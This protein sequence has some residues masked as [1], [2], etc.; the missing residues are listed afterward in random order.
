[1]PAN[2][3]NGFSGARLL[4][5][6][7][8]V[9]MLLVRNLLTYSLTVCLTLFSP[10][11]SFPKLLKIRVSHP[12]QRKAA[13]LFLPPA[14]IAL[15]VCLFGAAIVTSLAPAMAATLLTGKRHPNWSQQESQNFLKTINGITKLAA[16]SLSADGWRGKWNLGSKAFDDRKPTYLMYRTKAGF[17]NSRYT[18]GRSS[19][20][21]RF[22]MYKKAKDANGNTEYLNKYYR[23]I[24]QQ[25]NKNF[26]Y[27]LVRADNLGVGSN[28]NLFVL[29]TTSKFGF[30]DAK[31]KVKESST[32]KVVAVFVSDQWQIL[33]G[34][35]YDPATVKP[36]ILALIEGLGRQ[37]NTAITRNRVQPAKPKDTSNEG[38]VEIKLANPD[39]AEL[40]NIE[41]NFYEVAVPSGKKLALMKKPSVRSS[42]V[43]ALPNGTRDIRVRK[44]GYVGNKKWANLCASRKCGWAVAKHLRRQNQ[45]SSNN[46]KFVEVA[47][48]EVYV[49]EK[50]TVNS[51]K[52]K[53][54]TGGRKVALKEIITNANGDG[55]IRVCGTGWCGWAGQEFFN[56]AQ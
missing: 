21:I 19:M 46:I 24:S 42:V 20:M 52:I 13:S 16:Q 34:E 38:T 32:T 15:S 23:N 29:K 54:L 6:R 31:G 40:G 27:S 8:Y 28:S 51:Q 4:S 41:T 14:N 50:P 33:I 1:M 10:L 37:N 44:L 9:M 25:S 43:A 47:F 55:W 30:K 48:P 36:V 53:S 18:D 2:Y 39:D 45:K 12:G 49:F 5:A 26:S 22:T 17:E 7:I 35:A 56:P 11:F 3:N